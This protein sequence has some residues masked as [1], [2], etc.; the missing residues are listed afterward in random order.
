M[1]KGKKPKKEKKKTGASIGYDNCLKYEILM[2]KEGFIT[3]VRPI[4]ARWTTNKD[5]YNQFDIVG[6]RSYEICWVQVK[7]NQPKHAIDQMVSWIKKNCDY[8]PT[9]AKFRLVTL[10][11]ATKTLPKRWIIVK[12]SRHGEIEKKEEIV[13]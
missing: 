8:L 11:D 3:D 10:K 5:Y 7:T 4:P 13:C 2:N 1:V 9:N 6:M 12:V